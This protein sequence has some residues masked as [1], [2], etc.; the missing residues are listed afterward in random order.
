MKRY[1]RF[2]D[3]GFTVSD[4]LDIPDNA[5]IAQILSAELLPQYRQCPDYVESGW[6]FMGGL[7]VEPVP[8][9]APLPPSLEEV[10]RAKTQEI[11]NESNRYAALVKEGY[12]TLEVDSWAIQ[13]EQAQRVI[14]GETL[15]DDALLRVLAA[16]NNVTI[17]EFAG[18][19]LVNVAKA[20]A[21]TK[22]IVGQQQAFELRVKNAMTVEEVQAIEVVYILPGA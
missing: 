19:V 11:L 12:S 14:N 7:W 6:R 5:D 8:P 18:R 13:A 4:T 20:D 22:I 15:P 21:A 9:P 2:M 3:D 17:E 16:A 10:K 1:F